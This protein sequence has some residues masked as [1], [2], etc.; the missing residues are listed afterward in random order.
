MVNLISLLIL[1]LVI[2]SLSKASAQNNNISFTNYKLISGAAGQK[3]ATY[4]FSAV[5]KDHYGKAAADC[6]VKIESVSPGVNLKQLTHDASGNITSFQ[7]VVEYLD[8]NGPSWIEFSFTFVPHN[9][10]QLSLH[11]LD[12]ITTSVSGLNNYGIAQ[13]FAECNL[14]PNSKV[15]YDNEITNLMISATGTGFRAENKFGSKQSN[16]NIEKL[17]IINQHVAEIRIKIGINRNNNNWG[18]TSTYKIELKDANPDMATVY[19]PDIVGFQARM[20]QEQ[21]QLAWSSP[22]LNRIQDIVIEKSVD[23]EIFREVGR[24]NKANMEKSGLFQFNDDA[25]NASTMGAVFYR[26]RTRSM[27]GEIQYSSVKMIALNKKDAFVKTEMSID[28][29]TGASVLLTPISWQQ[30]EIFAEVFNAHGEL[31]KKVS[32]PKALPQM[33]LDMKE[34]AAGAYVVRFTCGKQYSTQYIIHGESL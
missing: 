26:L 2:F 3:G 33:S 10:T 24:F 13:E 29:V 21:V 1:L 20:Q 8:I 23:G 19:M 31:V 30:K 11:H 14:G 34:L 32:D 9:N 16:R 7:P 25:R 22:N 4:R 18:G 6:I 5:T 27:E 17:S 12:E 15:V 28:P